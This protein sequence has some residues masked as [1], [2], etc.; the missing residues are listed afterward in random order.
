MDEVVMSETTIIG[1]TDG[2]S[3]YTK[4]PFGVVKVTDKLPAAPWQGHNAAAAELQ[5]ILQWSLQ[6]TIRYNLVLIICY[7]FFDLKVR[8][9]TSMGLGAG[10]PTTI[11]APYRARVVW[12]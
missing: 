2:P 1:G 7:D 10:P 3:V 8:A 5:I 12:K 11:L 4:L 9:V 6:P